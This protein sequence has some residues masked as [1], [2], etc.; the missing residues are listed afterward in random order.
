M[1]KIKHLFVC[2]KDLK[3]DNVSCL[4]TK[5]ENYFTNLKLQTILHNEN[6]YLKKLYFLDKNHK[7]VKMIWLIDKTR[8]EIICEL[9]SVASNCNY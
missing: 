9:D 3:N 4:Y 5:I 7:I 6:F 8:S 2:Y 1:K